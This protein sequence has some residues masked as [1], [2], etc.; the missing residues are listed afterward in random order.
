MAFYTSWV[1]LQDALASAMQENLQLKE[2]AISQQHQTK[3][4]SLK[5]RDGE[6]KALTDEEVGVSLMGDNVLAWV[7]M[8]LERY[9]CP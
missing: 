2:D 8:P 3:S 9:G 7:K 6:Q 1:W 4:M 5:L